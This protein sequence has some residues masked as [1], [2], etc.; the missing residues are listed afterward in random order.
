MV[1]FEQLHKIIERGEK[2]NRLMNNPDFKEIILD[3]YLD[4]YANNLVLGL[5]TTRQPEMR[6]MVDDEL[7]GISAFNYYLMMLKAEYE[8]A[9]DAQSN[10]N[11]EEDAE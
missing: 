8:R 3:G 6:K 2:L 5:V 7:M 4:S 10:A 9:L 1:N 11:S